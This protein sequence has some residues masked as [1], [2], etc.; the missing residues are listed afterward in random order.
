MGDGQNKRSKKIENEFRGWHGML[1]VASTYGYLLTRKLHS[2]KVKKKLVH[3]ARAI[4]VW[5]IYKQRR[6]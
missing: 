3:C 2:S 1:P 4:L 6:A 5:M